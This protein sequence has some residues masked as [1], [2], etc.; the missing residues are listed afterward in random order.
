[1]KKLIYANILIFCLFLPCFGQ[2]DYKQVY[3]KSLESQINSSVGMNDEWGFSPDWYYNFLHNKYKSG[4]YEKNNSI[5]LSEMNEA[6]FKSLHQVGE[7]NAAITRVYE[8]EKKHWEDRRSNRELF[9]ILNDIEN[10]KYAIRVL[11]DEF[12]KHKVPAE[13]A[14]KIYDEYDRIN[15]KYFLIGDTILTHMD[16]QKRR[17]AYSVCLDEFVKLINVCY[18]INNY[19]LVASKEEEFNAI[20]KKK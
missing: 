6:A 18:R 1:M 11:T 14:Q 16:N 7:A 4:E 17:R 9:Q 13:E 10:S 8:N 19:C 2:T 5:P 20:I 12:S 3:D 15:Q